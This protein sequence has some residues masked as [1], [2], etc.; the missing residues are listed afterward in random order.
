M[1]I[2]INLGPV[3]VRCIIDMGTSLNPCQHHA[4]SVTIIYKNVHVVYMYACIDLYEHDEMHLSTSRWP[5]LMHVTSAIH[6]FF[7]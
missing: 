1:M 3:R 4:R 5:L 6:K 2:D 7:P